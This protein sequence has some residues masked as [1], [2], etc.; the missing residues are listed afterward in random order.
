LP[1][2]GRVLS[3]TREPN[4]GEGCALFLFAHPRLSLAN[5][6]GVHNGCWWGRV[7]HAQARTRVEW[8]IAA[9]SVRG[10]TT[11]GGATRRRN[12]NSPDGRDAAHDGRVPGADGAVPPGAHSGHG[13]VLRVGALP[14]ARRRQP[15]AG[16]AGEYRLGHA[17]AGRGAAGPAPRGGARRGVRTA[18][19]AWPRRRSRWRATT[20][21]RARWR[22][23]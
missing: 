4:F 13:G 10:G 17:R 2:W 21:T 23:W 22:G 8:G 7:V 9:F 1:G 20:R 12:L 16:A 6:C 5:G 11:L 18:E 15:R 19:A 3:C 14:R